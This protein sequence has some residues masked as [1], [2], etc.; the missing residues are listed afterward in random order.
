MIA[1]A[2]QQEQEQEHSSS[3]DGPYSH[4]SDA[5]LDAEIQEMVGQ[6]VEIEIQERPCPQ[7]GYVAN[8]STA[9]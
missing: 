6:L 4:L 2:M 9:T 5:E 1:F 8:P 3:E 7:C